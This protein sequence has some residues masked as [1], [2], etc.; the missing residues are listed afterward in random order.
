M[1]FLFHCFFDDETQETTLS[2]FGQELYIH[3]MRTPRNPITSLSP[4][5][6]KCST[7]NR[8]YWINGG[9]ES[10]KHPLTFMNWPETSVGP[11]CCYELFW[12]SMLG[13]SVLLLD[14]NNLREHQRQTRPLCNYDGWWQRWDK[15][16]TLSKPRKRP[17]IPLCWIIRMT[18]ASLPIT[19]LASF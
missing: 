10:E 1:L 15:S 18:I 6:W 11:R 7:W 17:A 12:H 8:A 13:F 19:A 5:N 14:I 9:W 4:A 2:A 3:M 16:W